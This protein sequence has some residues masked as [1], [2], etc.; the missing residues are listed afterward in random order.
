MGHFSEGL[1]KVQKTNKWGFIDKTGNFVVQPTFEDA[2]NFSEGLAAVQQGKEGKWGFIDKTG[3][4]VIACDFEKVGYFSNGIAQVMQSNKC[5]FIDKKGTL[6]LTP[7]Y[8]DIG[9]FSKRSYAKTSYQNKIGYLYYDTLQ[10]TVHEILPTIFDD[11]KPF[12]YFI[13]HTPDM[14]WAKLNG[15]VGILKN[16]VVVPPAKRTFTIKKIADYKGF[17]R[18]KNQAETFVLPATLNQ[19]QAVVEGKVNRL[20][21][22]RQITLKRTDGDTSEEWAFKTYFDSETGEFIANVPLK[23]GDNDFELT[24]INEYGQTAGPRK[25]RLNYTPDEKSIRSAKNIALIL[26][27]QNYKNDASLNLTYTKED[28]EKIA[29]V[30]QEEYNFESILL[31]PNATR[32][33]LIGTLDS[34]LGKLNTKHNLLI[35][36]AGHGIYNKTI[37]RTYWQLADAVGKQKDTWFSLSELLAYITAFDTQHTLLISDACYSGGIFNEMRGSDDVQADIAQKYKLKSRKALTSG[38]MTKV[39]DQSMFAELIARA[40]RENKNEF[41]TTQ[42]IYDKYLLPKLKKESKTEVDPI[43]RE[44]TNRNQGGDFIFVRKKK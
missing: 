8:R 3:K 33:E 31:K 12:P 24:A 40:L 26:Y 10:N 29:K 9:N 23:E 20:V 13:F 39:P 16:P 44:I 15:R 7:Q 32:A 27:A 14:W 4:V 17:D 41:L 34:L 38:N 6:L 1:A 22:P 35:Y 42:E 19:N 18:E 5:G 21:N 28:A 11:I 43:Y 37:E 25:I 30:L 2:L 36:Y